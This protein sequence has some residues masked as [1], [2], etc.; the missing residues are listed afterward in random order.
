MEAAE[1]TL[2]SK[3]QRAELQLEGAQTK[4]LDF[5]RLNDELK[6][7]NADLT[8]QLERWQNL[9]TKGGE[10]AEKEHQ[11]RVALEFELQELKE[12]HESQLEEHVNLVE[13]Y[14]NRY[15]KVKEKAATFEVCA[16]LLRRNNS[17]H[18]KL[19]SRM[20]QN[21]ERKR[22]TKR[23]NYSLNYRNNTIN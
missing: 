11:K 23:T 15:E 20:K 21:N 3:L 14:K 18:S 7:S 10:A 8:H 5:E 19:D 17:S 13:K 4:I 1:G 12:T 6:R 9:D 22:P 2:N 16:S